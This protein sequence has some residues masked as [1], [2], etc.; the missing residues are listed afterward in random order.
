ME[1]GVTDLGWLFT[2]GTTRLID[3]TPEVWT[4][5]RDGAVALSTVRM[6]CLVEEDGMS[7]TMMGIQCFSYI[8]NQVYI[9][10]SL[11]CSRD[12]ALQVLHGWPSAPHQ[13]SV[14]ALH[15]SSKENQAIFT[16]SYSLACT[17]DD[18]IGQF[19]GQHSPLAK[20]LLHL[21]AREEKL[22]KLFFRFV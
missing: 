16:G 20:I 11:S 22:N 5:K 13:L 6:P 7:H 4:G 15:R 17:I 21:V 18:K 12:G 19:M 9:T 14:I 2:N 1:S 10:L 3:Q 8:W